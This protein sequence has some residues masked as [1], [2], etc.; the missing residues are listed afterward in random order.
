MIFSFVYIDYALC[1]AAIF[2][3]WRI[4]TRRTLSLPPGP[5]GYP[6]IGNALD[7]PQSKPWETFAQ[8]GDRW[9]EASC[10]STCPPAQLTYLSTG[11]ITSVTVFRKPFIIL[12]SHRAAYALLDKRS[13]I[14]SERP[15]MVMAGQMMGWGE[16]SGLLPYGEELRSHR[17]MFH[18]LFGSKATIRK[19]Y[20]MEELEARKFMMRLLESP[21][22][23]R[24]HICQYVFTI[25]F[26]VGPS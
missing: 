20:P 8:W 16:I 12:N 4:L 15:N 2:F 19:F 21:E 5:R 7:M 10:L 25:L 6:I 22:N 1:L 17:K 24:A 9:G 14:Y 3:L 23:R 13:V 11:D 26:T 18:T